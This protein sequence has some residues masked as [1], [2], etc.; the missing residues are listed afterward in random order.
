[1]ARATGTHQPEATLTEAFGERVRSLRVAAGLSEE[2]LASRS[3][4]VRTT[5]IYKIELGLKEP[6]LS[7]ILKLCDGLRASPNALLRDLLTKYKR[8]R[9]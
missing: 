9:G 8:G 2:E 1:M 5:T 6:S 4:V 3:D 7:L